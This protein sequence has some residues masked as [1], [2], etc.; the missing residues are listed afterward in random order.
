MDIAPEIITELGLTDQQVEKIAGYVNENVSKL[1]SDWSARANVNAERIIEGAAKRIEEVTGI[2]RDKGQKLADYLTFASE[3]Y[4]KGKTSSIERKEQE[5]S[6]KLK[7]SGHNETIVQELELTKS[8]LDKLKAKEAQFADWE[9]NDYKGKYESVAKEH[10]T[11]KQE[12][13]FNKVKPN[14]PDTVNKFEA[15]YKW[16]AFKKQIL[17]KNIVQIVDGEAIAIDR[18]NNYKQFKLSDILNKDENVQSLLK[19]GED[20]IKGFGSKPKTVKLEG[21][22]FDVPE[23]VSPKDRAILIQDYIAKQGIPISDP[24]HPKLFA[25]LNMKILAQKTA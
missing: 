12:L 7:K 16:E 2:Q 25:E 18:E 15:D 17:E 23:N 5:L 19:G 11:L 13:A 1:E 22:P 9:T 20:K 8:Q 6:E 24:R 21:V 10:E 14:F 3:N 4:F